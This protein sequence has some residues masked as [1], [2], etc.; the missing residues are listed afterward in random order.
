MILDRLS[1]VTAAMATPAEAEEVLAF[2]V[3]ILTPQK[4][5]PLQPDGK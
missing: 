5:R 1:R 3:R 4:T 2:A